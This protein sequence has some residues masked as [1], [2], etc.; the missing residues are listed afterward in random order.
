MAMAAPNQPLPGLQVT[1]PDE[2]MEIS[3]YERNADDIDI[4]IDLTVDPSHHEDENMDDDRSEN[5]NR[6]DVMLDGDGNDDEDG[7]MQ[8]NVSVPDEHLTDASDVGL[9]DI[10]VKEAPQAQPGAAQVDVE[11]QDSGQADDYIDYDDTI[12]AQAQAA[13]EY[14]QHGDVHQ[15]VNDQNK[16]PTATDE[17]TQQPSIQPQDAESV[18]MPQPTD[19][20]QA[21]VSVED[22]T[23]VQEFPVDP[24]VQSS[25]DIQGVPD[26]AVEELQQVENTAEPPS[27]PDFAQTV[28]VSRVAA[29]T[30]EG[31]HPAT[32]APGSSHQDERGLEDGHQAD[33][34]AAAEAPEQHGD[35]EQAA[36]QSNESFDFS[37][38]P[39]D[40]NQNADEQSPHP[41]TSL[42]AVVVVYQGDEISLFPPDESDTSDSFYFLQDESLVHESIKTLLQACRQVLGETVREEDELEIDIAE[43]GLCV[44]ED[45]IH[46]TDTSFAQ[47][48]DVYLQL[49]Q[50]DGHQN[51]GPLYLTLNTKTRFSAR[52]QSLH[53]AIADGRGLSQLSLLDNVTEEEAY[54]ESEVGSEEQLYQEGDQ[55]S[56]NE[57]VLGHDASRAGDVDDHSNVGTGMEHRPGVNTESPPDEGPNAPSEKHSP[58]LQ[59]QER[60]S[61]SP[62]EKETQSYVSPPTEKSQEQQPSEVGEDVPNKEESVPYVEDDPRTDGVVPENSHDNDQIDY[63]DGEN[64]DDAKDDASYRSSTLQGDNTPALLEESTPQR[65]HTSGLTVNDAGVATTAIAGL[66]R[67][68]SFDK[69]AEAHSA[70]A[71]AE[72][73]EDKPAHE[74]EEDPGPAADAEASAGVEYESA[75]VDQQELSDA[76]KELEQELER[77]LNNQG[78]SFDLPYDYPEVFDGDG[79]EY[80][81][82]LEGGEEYSYEQETNGQE[83]QEGEESHEG[84]TVVETGNTQESV[85]V[86]D[87]GLP[88]DHQD[89]PHGDGFE[90]AEAD[91]TAEN[92]LDGAHSATD[93]D[94]QVGLGERSQP[95]AHASDEDE[96]DTI[97]YDDEELSEHD[98]AAVQSPSS[99]KR[100]W[101]ELG[102]DEDEQADE[103]APKKVKSE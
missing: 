94:L 48:L 82:D 19:L 45:S 26:H 68:G 50:L 78:A 28:D 1:A 69:S 18:A 40:P 41:G 63:D 86:A 77:E 84:Y 21:P 51:P 97:D 25:G 95:N 17:T 9:V 79:E 98:E 10:E 11:V 14:S 56:V 13:P 47:I 65:D 8:D 49:H 74:R 36:E 87:N 52:M 4:D 102:Q 23:Q 15:P 96:L 42:H 31:T 2:D 22:Q 54:V 44:S 93:K 20:S 75:N 30:A 88:A 43:L 7:M 80:S 55:H 57:Q 39:F 33:I 27:A 53:A 99:G 92:D 3:D 62:A 76:D 59:S 103:Q 32:E 12:E 38:L 85:N 83:T 101:E 89:T 6:D 16:L 72:S 61:R 58:S 71:Y 73:H 60:T 29:A 67:G 90:D 81:A 100:G 24:Q 91:Q 70:E 46:A 64:A 37:H 34:T 66:P 35:S 5:D